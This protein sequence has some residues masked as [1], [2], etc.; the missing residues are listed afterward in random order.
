MRSFL[1]RLQ[2]ILDLRIH[3][4]EQLRLELGVATSRCERVRQEISE[5]ENR[6]RQVLATRPDGVGADDVAWRTA[7]EAYALRLKT[8]VERLHDQL[9]DAETERTAATERYR[10]AKQK[11]DVLT[12][13]RERRETAHRDEIKREEQHRLDE[14]SQ[15]VFSRG[16]S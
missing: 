9:R 6:R 13:L 2:S 12:K 7:S 3:E 15:Y 4:E 8:E 10:E 16:G 1:F 11:A 5:R 14:A